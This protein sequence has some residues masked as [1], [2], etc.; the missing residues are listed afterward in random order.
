MLAATLI[1][2]RALLSTLTIKVHELF[3]IRTRAS[4]S[5]LTT[6]AHQPYSKGSVME[7]HHTKDMS[8]TQTTRVAILSLLR[9]S[10]IGFRLV[11]V[12]IIKMVSCLGRPKRH[13]Y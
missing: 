1:S 11:M 4:S 13:Q 7:S 3:M 8:R 9:T 10:T 2:T 12:M 6:K 5:I